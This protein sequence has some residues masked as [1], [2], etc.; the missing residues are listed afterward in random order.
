MIVRQ[1]FLNGREIE[2]NLNEAS[3]AREVE[4][5]VYSILRNGKSYEVRVQPAPEGYSIEAG[6]YRFQ[7]EVRDPRNSGRRRN[8]TLGSG[9]QKITSPMPGKVVRVLVIEG[10]EIEPGQGLIIV[11]A[12][13]MQNEM[14]AS[15]AGRV[16]E[17]KTRDGATVSAGEVL[18]IIE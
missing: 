11:E 9:R 2:L 18:A 17:I 7:A 6:G 3:D 14:K 10:Q 16:V 1:I 8:S 5:G 13:K 12:M 4:P 15:K